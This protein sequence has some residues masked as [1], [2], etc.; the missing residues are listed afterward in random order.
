MPLHYP[1]RWGVKRE[2]EA[3]SA[4]GQHGLFQPGRLGGGSGAGRTLCPKKR[5]PRYARGNPAQHTRWTRCGC[6][7]PPLVYALAGLEQ[8]SRALRFGR[9][10]KPPI[11]H[12]SVGRPFATGVANE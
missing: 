5:A 11:I 10:G 4:A 2:N 12:L 8:D 6:G 1:L 3:A 9:R 7:V